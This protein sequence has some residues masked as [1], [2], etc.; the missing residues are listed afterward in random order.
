MILLDLSVQT[1][2]LDYTVWLHWDVHPLCHHVL[3]LLLLECPSGSSYCSLC[4]PCSLQRGW[5]CPWDSGERLTWRRAGL[6]LCEQGSGL[7]VPS[8]GKREDVIQ[9]DW[10]ISAKEQSVISSL[11]LCCRVKCFLNVCSFSAS[12]EFWVTSVA[13]SSSIRWFFLYG[14]WRSVLRCVNT[15][16]A[17]TSF[18]FCPT[19]CKNR[20]KR[21]WQESF[22]QHSGYVF[23]VCVCVRHFFFTVEYISGLLAGGKKLLVLHVVMELWHLAEFGVKYP[24]LYSWQGEWTVGGSHLSGWHVRVAGRW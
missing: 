6:A 10:S 4:G 20:S 2:N 12:W 22:L 18:L 9:R 5:W 17:T 19:S 15:C 13:F 11:L 21:K 24:S 1:E 7:L 23:C 3:R 16:D 8:G 14:S